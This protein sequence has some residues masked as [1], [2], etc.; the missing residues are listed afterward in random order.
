MGPPP[1]TSSVAPLRNASVKLCYPTP[2]HPDWFRICVSSWKPGKPPQFL[3]TSPI[4]NQFTDRCSFAPP[5][6][7]RRNF[8]LESLLNQTMFPPPYAR[9]RQRRSKYTSEDAWVR[10]ARFCTS[11]PAKDSFFILRSTSRVTDNKKSLV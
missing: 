11:T 2:T 7:R 5:T 10:I 6:I 8:L 1:F 4:P 3:R 9:R